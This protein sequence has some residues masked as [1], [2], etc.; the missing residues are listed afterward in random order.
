MQPDET[1]RSKGGAATTAAIKSNQEAKLQEKKNSWCYEWISAWR[2]KSHPNSAILTE[3]TQKG[4]DGFSS[5][6]DALAMSNSGALLACEE[7]FVSLACLT[8]MMDL[9]HCMEKQN[10]HCC[11]PASSR[12]AEPTLLFKKKQGFTASGQ[13]WLSMFLSDRPNAAANSNE[14]GQ[15]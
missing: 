3:S 8:P 1:T 14:I 6:S 15:I 11:L 7:P 10:N 13:K 12:L 9:P 5:T 4:N 2:T